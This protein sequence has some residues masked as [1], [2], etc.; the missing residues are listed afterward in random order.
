MG[1]GGGE[2]TGPMHMV[3]CSHRTVPPQKHLLFPCVNFSLSN[4]YAFYSTWIE[5][6]YTEIPLCVRFVC[7]SHFSSRNEIHIEQGFT[8]S[9]LENIIMLNQ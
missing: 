3:L 9:M 6:F 1:G 5:T 8:S 4:K 7:V 2:R